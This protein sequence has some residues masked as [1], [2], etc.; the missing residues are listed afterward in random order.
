MILFLL[1]NVT[2]QK[3]CNITAP[4]TAIT[5]TVVWSSPCILFSD[6]GV[7]VSIYVVECLFVVEDD[8]VWLSFDIPAP[9]EVGN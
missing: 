6:F 3:V 5:I 1:K 7:L 4:T 2:R 9:S 8:L